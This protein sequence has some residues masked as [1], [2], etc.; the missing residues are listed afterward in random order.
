[1]EDMLQTLIM[2][3]LC[4]YY[5]VV[6]SKPSVDLLNIDIFASSASTPTGGGYQLPSPMSPLSDGAFPGIDNSAVTSSPLSL[7]SKWNSYYTPLK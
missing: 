2:F 3:M 7:A 1:M 5:S 6:T 4:L